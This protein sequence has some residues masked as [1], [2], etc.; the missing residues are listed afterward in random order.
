MTFFEETELLQLAAF[1]YCLGRRS[2]IVDPCCEYLIKNWD[3]FLKSTQNIIREEITQ[4]IV[5]KN[6]GMSCDEACWQKVLDNVS[7]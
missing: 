7:K 4:A 3:S 6:C 2:Y 5:T 1:R